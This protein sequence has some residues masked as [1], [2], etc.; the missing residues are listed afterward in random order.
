M[1]VSEDLFWERNEHRGESRLLTF[2]IVILKL[3][4]DGHKV[5]GCVLG[6]SLAASA[7]GSSQSWSLPAR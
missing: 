7:A 1:K 5:A 6:G 2:A 3:I 4:W